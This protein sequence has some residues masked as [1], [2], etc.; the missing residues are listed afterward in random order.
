MSIEDWSDNEFRLFED[1]NLPD[2]AFDDVFVQL[3]YDMAFFSPDAD[4]ETHVEMKRF[5]VNHLSDEYGFDFRSEFNWDEYS[6]NGESD[7]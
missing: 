3:A 1:M 7:G 4:Y 2:E 6:L 5:L